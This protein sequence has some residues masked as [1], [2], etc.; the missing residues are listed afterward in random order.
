MV[1]FTRTR[2]QGAEV[3]LTPLIDVV[4]QLL[5]FFLLTSTLLAQSIPIDLPK[6]AT[7][8]EVQRTLAIGIDARG[9]IY[10]DGQSI[11]RSELRG[12]FRRAK[13]DADDQALRAVI[14]ADGQTPHAQV[15][16]VLDMLRLEGLSNM[17]FQ[18]EAA[19]AAP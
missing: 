5:V 3:E 12:R 15:I 10:L 16:E 18:I 19:P 14:A 2:R 11:E 8:Q 13:Q 4:F 6:A 9:Q 17:A 7:G 1:E